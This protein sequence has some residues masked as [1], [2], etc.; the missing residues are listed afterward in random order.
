MLDPWSKLSIK[1]ITLAL[2]KIQNYLMEHLTE[3]LILAMLA[4]VFLQS[5]LDKITDRKGNLDWLKG[6]FANSIF[7]NV[8][9]LNLTIVTVLEI[10]SGT[11]AV[12]GIVC[13]LIEGNSSMALLSGI[14]SSA[15]FL[16]LFLGQRLAKDY[17]GAQTIVIYLMPTFFLLYLLTQ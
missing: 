3:I 2:L 14:L 6:H 4:I 16:C 7:K 8:V 12:I 11:T 9:A 15:T 17:V 10:L 1:S 5:G 13:L